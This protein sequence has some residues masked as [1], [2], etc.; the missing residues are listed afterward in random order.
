TAAEFK[1]N[2]FSI[3]IIAGE[4]SSQSDV[5]GQQ[6]A[7]VT[8]EFYDGD[9]LINTQ[10]VKAGDEL[11][12]PGIPYLG[13]TGDEKGRKE[14]DGWYTKKDNGQFDQKVNFGTVSFVENANSTIKAYAKIN[15]TYYVTFLGMGVN[16]D[17]TDRE[18]VQVKKV[19]LDNSQSTIISVK[20]VSVTPKLA[21][22]AFDGWALSPDS[23]QT[24]E[25]VDAATTDTVYAVVVNAHWITFDKN[26]SGATY[27]GKKY[28]KDGET[29]TAP[30]EPSRAGYDFLG[31]YTE[32]EGG[33]EFTWDEELTKDITLYA[34]WKESSETK[35]T[36][37]VWK[38]QVT[39]T[40]NSSDKHYDFGASMEFE[41]QTGATLSENDINTKVAEIV[42]STANF[43]LDHFNK[44]DSK[45]DKN[46]TINAKGDT[47]V[48]VYY[49]REVFNIKFI[50]VTAGKYT[51]VQSSDNSGT[52][53]YR[54][55]D[56][57]Y[58]PLY[59]KSSGSNKG[60]YKNQYFTGG[61]YSGTRY[62]YSKDVEE[63]ELKNI[64]G[65]Y[66]QN[67]NQVPGAE[68][69]SEYEWYQGYAYDDNNDR[70]NGTG[71]HTTFLASFLEN[72][73]LYG[74]VP[75]YEPYSEYIETEKQ[76]G[77]V[78]YDLKYRDDIVPTEQIYIYHYKQD[79][80]GSY[81]ANNPTN[82]VSTYDSKITEYLMFRYRTRN[83]WGY[84]GSW[85]NWSDWNYVGEYIK[86]SNF[87]FTD[88][89]EGFSVYEYY[90]G[91]SY[92]T[93][94]S[95][96]SMVSE[97]IPDE[98]GERKVSHQGQNLY[99]RHRRNSGNIT[100]VENFKGSTTEVGSG[101]NNIPFEKD[102]AAYSGSTPEVDTTGKDGFTF[103]GWFKDKNGTELFQW[104]EEKMPANNLVLYGY[105]RPMEYKV[106]L[107][108][109]ADDAQWIKPYNDPAF[110]LKYI[111][112]TDEFETVSQEDIS[113]NVK[114]EKWELVGWFVQGTDQPYDFGQPTGDEEDIY[115]VARWRF[116]GVVRIIYEAGTEAVS[117]PTD[118]F[119][120]ATN[121]YVVVAAPPTG[122]DD[123]HTF[124]GWIVEG[125]DG[126]VLLPNNSF[127]IT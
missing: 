85:S 80:D 87:I 22:Q 68:W 84:W 97:V 30:A 111:A 82:T 5:D 99:I 107:D 71:T 50:T 73:T 2:E 117:A 32:A 21:T 86:S 89:Y 35:Y 112:A 118:D 76:D 46:V 38:Q 75:S 42:A 90:I 27:T 44:N 72:H 109:G 54:D 125:G 120:Y 13:K 9:T 12:S 122:V 43:S 104:N 83:S 39:D 61:K 36:V 15:T 116:P 124:K 64:S 92:P 67:F 31:W 102:L 63:S 123:E 33:E 23:K 3:F 11:V 79:V 53:Y 127:Q 114:R 16:G 78:Q 98:D 108:K 91:D 49:D 81:N 17:G 26:G 48:N 25:T 14:F 40:V 6:H 29:A 56:G 74:I 119:N 93:D 20:G 88:K 65:L 101:I 94:E 1:V 126:K 37:I 96:W 59:Y 100:F 8:Y 69:P 95:A 106:H 19:T 51:Q 10:T 105:W 58:K 113:S 18:I 115:L 28:V 4:G 52:Q 70:L 34:H 45:S 62:K 110:T 66:E 103:V 47:I 60:W 7:V 57:T 41:G 121:S 77:N 55:D 24:V